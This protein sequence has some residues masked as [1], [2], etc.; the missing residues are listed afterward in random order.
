MCELAC[1]LCLGLVVVDRFVG[2]GTGYFPVADVEG[3]VPC[4]RLDNRISGN[5][6]PIC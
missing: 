5:K 3:P 6:I 2:T 1:L 4:M